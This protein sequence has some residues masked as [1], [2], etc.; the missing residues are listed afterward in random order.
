MIGGAGFEKGAWIWVPDEE[1]CWLPGRCV[2]GFAA[3]CEGSVEVSGGRVIRVSKSQS[4][5]CALL[6]EESLGPDKEDMVRLNDLSEGPL[7]HNLRRR[8]GA[9]KIY[10]WVGSIL[11]ALNP[12]RVLPLY[13]PEVVSRYLKGNENGPH[14]YGIASMAYQGLLNG[15]SQAICISGESGA[16]KTES[17]KLMLQFLAE[18]SGRGK[19]E[20]SILRTNPVTESFGN[21]KTVRNNNSSRFGKWT[22]L[23]FSKAGKINGA[24]IVNYLLEKSRVTTQ[25]DGERGYHSFYQLLARDDDDDDDDK[26]LHFAYL[27]ED[28]PVDFDDARD[29]DD[30]SEALEALQISDGVW[31]VARTVL[32]LG[33]VEFSGDD[34]DEAKVSS[35]LENVSDV[36]DPEAL[37]EGLVAKNIGNSRSVIRTVLSASKA[38]DARDA[39]ARAIYARL[40]DYL[41]EKI[42]ATLA[43]EEKKKKNSNNN[44]SKNA[45]RRIGVLDIFGFEFFEVNSFEQ[46]C[47]NYCNEKLQFHFNDHIFSQEG[48]EYEREGIDL[49]LVA[50]QN[51]GP[52]LALLEHKRSGVLAMLDEECA[53]PRGSD[54]SYLRKLCQKHGQDPNFEIRRL[55]KTPSFGIVHY[56]STVEYAAE[57]FLEKN[58]DTLLSALF[59]VAAASEHLVMRDLFS[60]QEDSG[61]GGK[62]RT[63]GGTFRSQ[64]SSLVAALEACEPNF[65]RCIKPNAPKEPGLF[66]AQMVRSQMRC[67]GVLEVCK[68]RRAGF[69]YRMLFADFS[70]RYA[71]VAPW[72]KTHVDLCAALGVGVV[73]RTKIFLRSKDDLEKRREEALLHL[74]TITQAA[75]RGLLGRRRALRVR[76]TLAELDA[77]TSASDVLR[78]EELL[79]SGIVLPAKRCE[80]ARAFLEASRALQAKL[81][82]LRRAMERREAGA[83]RR[84]VD[85]LKDQKNPPKQL[86]DR[87]ERLALRIEREPGVRKAL[88]AA[89][90][91]RDLAGLRVAL[92]EAADLELDLGLEAAKA[93]LAELEE[94]QEVEKALAR[95]GDDLE[96]WILRAAELGVDETA[97][98]GARGALE[99]RRAERR[100]REAIARAQQSRDP[101]ELEAMMDKITTTSFFL[102]EEA[103]AVLEELREEA[104]AV[105]G[106]VE[107]S[108]ELRALEAAI[109]RAQRFVDVSERAAKA[110]EGAERRRSRL[111]DEQTAIEAC[112]DAVMREP[113][114]AAATRARALGL[115]VPPEVAARLAL[116][117]SLALEAERAAQQ[118]TAQLELEA[119]IDANLENLEALRG[120]LNG[121]RD[122]TLGA[123]RRGRVALDR[124]ERQSAARH[125]AADAV[126]VEE[127][128]RAIAACEA[129]GV[130]DLLSDLRNRL[131]A[132]E[133]G[134]A[135]AASFDAPNDDEFENALN[136]AR[137]AGADAD[138]LRRAEAHAGKRARREEARRALRRATAGGNNN[139]K[140]KEALEAALQTALDLGIFSG[141]R[142][143]EAAEAEIA[144]IDEVRRRAAR[145]AA[146]PLDEAAV[147]ALAAVANEDDDESSGVLRR[148]RRLARIASL[149]NEAIRARDADVLAAALAEVPEE[150]EEEVLRSDIA[151]AARLLSRLEAE[152]KAVGALR[153]AKATGAGLE[154][155]ISEA[156]ALLGDSFSSSEVV[157]AALAE[158]TEA[159]SHQR[160]AE[161][162]EKRARE[163]AETKQKG[164]LAL[165]DAVSRAELWLAHPDATPPDLDA[166]L[167]EA[168]AGC[169]L[170]AAIAARDE[171]VEIVES[172]TA[173][174]II[175]K[176]DDDVDAL[177]KAIARCEKWASRAE[178]APFRRKLRRAEALANLR[179]SKEE[180]DLATALI[181]AA[182]REVDPAEIAKA[183]RAKAR[184][185]RFRRLEAKLATE[186][187]LAAYDRLLEEAESAA[188]GAPEK[189]SNL[190]AARERRE[191]L[192][193]ARRARHA[194]RRAVAVATQTRQ[195]EPLEAALAQGEEGEDFFEAEEL[196]LELRHEASA[197]RALKSA[198][199]D[200]ELRVAI[201]EARKFGG[202]AI[203]IAS[204]E[205]AL[206]QAES[207]RA[208]IATRDA[209]VLEAALREAPIA[210]LSDL[211]RQTLSEVQARERE[212]VAAER[213]ERRASLE[214]AMERAVA[215]RDLFLLE[216]FLN[217]AFFDVPDFE[218]SAEDMRRS[219]RLVAAVEAAL[220]GPLDALAAAREAAAAGAIFFA[221]EEDS[222]VILERADERLRKAVVLRDAVSR[223]RVESIRVL[224]LDGSVD[225]SLER[226]AR[227][228]VE[229]DENATPELVA[230]ATARG[231]EGPQLDAARTELDRR[232]ADALLAKATEEAKNASDDSLREATAA[233]EAA[234]DESGGDSVAASTS[235]ARALLAKC[236]QRLA[237]HHWSRFPGLRTAPEFS[238]GLYAVAAEKRR[239]E[240]K[241]LRYQTFPLHK[242][243][244]RRA[245][246]DLAKV[247]HRDILAFC[248]ELYHQFPDEMALDLLRKGASDSSLADEILLQVM[249]HL[250]A[251]DKPTSSARA[252][253]LLILCVQTFK[254][255]PELEP[256]VRAFEADDPRAEQ[257]RAGLDADP[258]PVPTEIPASNN[259]N[260]NN[261]NSQQPVVVVVTPRERR[262]ST[263]S[264]RKERLDDLANAS[265]QLAELRPDLA[266]ALAAAT[267]D[268][269]EALE[270]DDPDV[271]ADAHARLE[272]ATKV[273]EAQSE[274]PRAVSR[275]ATLLKSRQGCEEFQLRDFETK[276]QLATADDPNPLLD[277]GNDLLRKLK[278]QLE[279]RDA[280]RAA[281]DAP[282]CAAALKAAQNAR[283]TH[284]LA[285]DDCKKL[286]KSLDTSLTAYVSNFFTPT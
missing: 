229:L 137:A 274:L 231:L 64:L 163:A 189:K 10:T 224:L 207:L 54:A 91:R 235:A 120:L 22:T 216:K 222:S 156:Y 142:E 145:C 108:D 247:C 56:A 128:R 256:Y 105:A 186:K 211:A 19:I 240:D 162:A 86:I 176:S 50:F 261:N 60:N 210:P 257:V 184:L 192:A 11:I 40:F 239:A 177:R 146:N 52:T 263:L 80:A 74:V 213:R 204:A 219:D 36:L 43:W 208:A 160:R 68:I 38:R 17:M 153:A 159:L 118:A 152:A 31:G 127:L 173:L 185:D 65:V 27:A 227:I 53:V 109:S 29:Y 267:R 193:A 51:N 111:R 62:K 122:E 233:L 84:A 76:E 143:V 30:V 59:D 87:A 124:L 195:P 264:M 104:E 70:R 129:A 15:K 273:A 278:N 214:R 67:A 132:A 139:H 154:A 21:A 24:K 183:E 113:L 33:N 277:Q 241:R 82:D 170:S 254:P 69:P 276:L 212:A 148:A 236:R 198:A 93:T 144:R 117:D 169:D 100:T 13:S 175:S 206:A 164:D 161:E 271:V 266:D 8:Y 190:A 269:R 110:V 282:S 243:L 265:S 133:A 253:R 202:L 149:L 141:G 107:A 41:I 221:G 134:A 191:R 90:R 203:E 246:D 99:K 35:S 280:L 249:K 181:R 58:K 25:A 12:F 259:N 270:S 16:G 114:R 44:N 92:S 217:E 279:I 171:V 63:L 103:R 230:E 226:D 245:P 174:E 2:E 225:P 121:A 89:T 46:L 83:I 71:C 66:D 102:T 88:A 130:K 23:E 188:A 39:F 180:K 57:G 244:S 94:R 26:D 285:Y 45:S 209:E 101:T 242:S 112:R 215:E 194:V 187:D 272:R 55:A 37:E 196:L 4:A 167:S 48:A 47:I 232:R 223:R 14:C 42:N 20:E 251:N 151:A 158:A 252:W 147:E 5:A 237:G 179:N 81:E 116:L 1:E 119:A 250:T 6:D 197:R 178:L 78:V 18:A 275:A 199:D 228:L 7:L 138:L 205:K 106:L 96:K 268:V 75:S 98:S 123:V 260:N 262:Q 166:V 283:Q 126:E 135:L 155:A 34:D 284:L 3:G 136:A 131:R 28:V 95:G 238:R 97:I 61:G 79:S 49:S 72:A 85:G 218:R 182:A 32:E 258:T 140:K 281:N 168:P 220:D 172:R 150:E 9:D 157:A 165:R 201:F 77:A 125:Q 200:I 248:G 234:I 255:S 73:G 286:Y 115:T